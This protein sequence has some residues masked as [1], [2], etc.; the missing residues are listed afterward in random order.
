VEVLPLAPSRRSLQLAWIVRGVVLVVIAVVG[1][2][3]ATVVVLV[4]SGLPTRVLAGG[5]LLLL[6]ALGQAGRLLIRAATLPPGRVELRDDGLVVHSR[7]VLAMPLRVDRDD[8]DGVVFPSPSGAVR[9]GA[10]AHVPILSAHAKLDDVA[11]VVLLRGSRRLDGVLWGWAPNLFL[12]IGGA[13]YEGPVRKGRAGAIALALEDRE[14]AKV[15]FTAWGV[16]TSL[17]P[18]EWRWLATR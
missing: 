1:A 16:R 13:P 7:A 15:A 18:D 2:P 10:L 8:V 3:I 6:I 14:A 5:V 4:A 12:R 11:A 17:T 9:L